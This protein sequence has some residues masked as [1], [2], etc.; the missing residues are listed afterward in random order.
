MTAEKE[1][2]TLYL[3]AIK[4]PETLKQTKGGKIYYF[5]YPRPPTNRRFILLNY[6]IHLEAVES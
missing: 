5:M 1:R 6:V 2:T 4:S 3:V